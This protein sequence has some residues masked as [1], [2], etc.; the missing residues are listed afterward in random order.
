LHY[1]TSIEVFKQNKLFGVG[2]KNFRNESYKEKYNVNNTRNVW[3]PHP[4][5]IH[6]EFLSELGIVGYLMLMSLLIYYITNGFILY[7]KNNNLYV[8]SASL[9]ILAAILPII[10]S[11]SF[12]TTFTAS[13]FWINFS[14]ILKNKIE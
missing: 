12:F 2:F 5:Q 3:A 14:I 10:P 8:L 4:H 1:V 13:I 9:F 6:F 11:G 7:K